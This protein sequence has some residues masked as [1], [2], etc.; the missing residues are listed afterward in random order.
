MNS[1]V[2]GISLVALLCM[3]LTF[4]VNWMFILPAAL[5]SGWGWKILIEEKK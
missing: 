2:T 3:V 5:L 4:T 1:K